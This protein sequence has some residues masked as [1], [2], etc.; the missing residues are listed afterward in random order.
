MQLHYTY[1]SRTYF[2]DFLAIYPL[3]ILNILKPTKPISIFL[4]LSTH[5][6]IYFPLKIVV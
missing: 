2:L 1:D 6:F 5:S 3:K 4:F